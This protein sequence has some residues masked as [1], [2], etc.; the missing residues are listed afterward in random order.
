MGNESNAP[1]GRRPWQVMGGG[2]LLFGGVVVLSVWLLGGL[3]LP[4]AE[5]TLRVR[6]KTVG[7]DLDP[8]LKAVG[9]SGGVLSSLRAEVSGVWAKTG[10]V[11]VSWQFPEVL[12]GQARK[13][14]VDGLSGAIDL[15]RWIPLSETVSAPSPRVAPPPSR[16]GPVVPPSLPPAPVIARPPPPLPAQQEA[17]VPATAGSGGG[18]AS[19]TAE[20]PLWWRP[21]PFSSLLVGTSQLD[22]RYG[23][24]SLP[25]TTGL[26]VD[27][28]SGERRFDLRIAGQGFRSNASILT[29][30]E[31]R[32][33]TATGQWQGTHPASLLHELFPQ[34]HLLHPDTYLGPYVSGW[35]AGDLTFEALAE[36]TDREVKRLS[37]LIDHGPLRAQL[38]DQGSFLLRAASAGVT[39][40][41]HQWRKVEAVFEF[42]EVTLMEAETA[43][44]MVDLSWAID[45]PA[46]LEIPDL[47]VTHPSG[48]DATVSAR[49]FFELDGSA[50]VQLAFT[51]LM[52][53]THSLMPFRWFLNRRDDRISAQVSDLRSEQFPAWQVSRMEWTAEALPR[54]ARGPAP[55]KMVGSTDLEYR[56]AMRSLAHLDWEVVTRGMNVFDLKLG[57]T[58]EIGERL[59]EFV[60]AVSL[61]GGFTMRGDGDLALADTI[62]YVFPFL[63][64]LKGLGGEGRLRWDISAQSDPMLG[65]RGTFRTLFVGAG[66]RFPAKDVRIEGLAGEVVLNARGPF[67]ASS[68]EQ[69]LTIKKIVMGE[70]EM[71]DLTLRFRWVHRHELQILAVE[72][73]WMGG[74]IALDPFSFDPFDPRISTTMR[75]TG[76]ESKGLFPDSDAMGF[77]LE[78]RFS[79][80]IPLQYSKE[81]GFLLMRGVLEAVN[82]AK[83]ILRLTDTDAVSRF[84]PLPDTFKLK[85]KVMEAMRKDFRFRS[86]RIDLLNPETP[87]EPMVI[88]FEGGVQTP[89]VEMK[90]IRVR[91]PQRFDR[92]L[93]GW[94]GIV[95]LL[96]GGT[97]GL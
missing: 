69:E 67:V 44:F 60:G 65:A 64:T 70:E 53:G 45:Q 11:R 48:L 90:S 73:K 1:R 55:W 13:V 25:I 77:L 5:R 72:G 66:L 40:D 63:P 32:V 56:P 96:S 51:R 16:M 22:L 81:K 54:P 20:I 62:P 23:E 42:D 94:E 83:A 38:G 34:G 35:R 95:V 33:W 75:M 61:D 79:G 57:V 15:E 59:G 78:A 46:R 17:F 52:Y 39:Y 6:A 88:E 85:G 97:V 87:L 14:E 28:N 84:L 76:V 26:E 58:G 12:K 21:L 10:E 50:E 82:P 91:V 2:L 18:A 68:G 30:P 27:D 9:L 93:R 92:P 41:D 8:K 74:T 29:R 7:V 19:E 86:L 71:T 3:T 24:A 80:S 37:V 36:G 47:R 43:S 31:S 49:G 89:E 4:W